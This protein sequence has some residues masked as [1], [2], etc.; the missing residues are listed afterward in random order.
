MD[1]SGIPAQARENR[2][3]ARALLA[4]TRNIQDILLAARDKL[5]SAR[6]WGVMDILG[7][8]FITNMVKH[9]KAE[10][11]MYY[12]DQARP[13]LHRLGQ[14]LRQVRISQQIGA[15]ISGFAMVADFFFDGVFADVYMQSK[16]NDLRMQ[17]ERT[18]DRLDQVEEALRKVDSFE[19]RRLA[20][21]S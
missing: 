20:G 9:S 7:G 2:E 11:A 21:E 8:G 1:Y 14:E 19:A 6:N 12:V 5:S 3:R 13:L 18:L 17:V 4:L 16:I 10:D 15:D